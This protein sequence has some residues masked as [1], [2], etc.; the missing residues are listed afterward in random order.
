MVAIKDWTEP[1][2]VCACRGWLLHSNDTLPWLDCVRSNHFKRIRLWLLFEGAQLWRVHSC[3]GCTAVKGAQLWRVHS[4]EGCTAVKGAQLWR[5]HSCEGCT[6]VKGA[7]L[8]R[9]VSY[10]VWVWGSKVVVCGDPSPAQHYT[11]TC[12]A[13]NTLSF[14]ICSDTIWLLCVLELTCL[15]A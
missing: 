3:E 9:G 11:S 5:V 2:C 10:L 7:Q 13:I 12:S 4:C 1:K 15:Q 8:L 14:R 6:A